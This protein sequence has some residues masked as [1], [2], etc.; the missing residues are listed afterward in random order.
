[1]AGLAA[2]PRR[3]GPGTNSISSPVMSRAVSSGSATN[4]GSAGAGGGASNSGSLSPSGIAF[5]RLPQLE[6][7]TVRPAAGMRSSSTK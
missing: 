4:S 6:H 5:Q 7:F 1:L 3:G 2:L